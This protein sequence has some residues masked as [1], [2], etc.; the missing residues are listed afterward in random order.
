MPVQF[1]TVEIPLT[2][3]NQ[4]VA[5]LLRGPGTFDLVINGEY[6]KDGGRI[7]KRRGYQFVD[8]QAVVGG[9]DADAVMTHCTTLRD[10]LVIFTID[11]VLGLGDRGAALRGEDALVFRGPS[12]RGAA[13]MEFVAQ[14]RMSEEFAE[15]EGD[16]EGGE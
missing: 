5:R 9:S 4:K 6:A 13:R 14:S 16:P 12:N 15:P 3:L 7:N 10:E 11:T 2:G 8:S 1:Q